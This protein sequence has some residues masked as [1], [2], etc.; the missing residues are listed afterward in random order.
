MKH[1]KL[2]AL[3]LTLIFATACKEDKKETEQI[4]ETEVEEVAEGTKTEKSITVTM[5]PKSDSN[6]T[7]TVVFTDRDGVVTMEGKFSGLTE[8]VHAIHLHEKADCSSP[9]GKSS[10]GHWNPTGQPHGAWGAESGFHKGDIGNMTANAEGNAEISLTTDQWC[11]GCGDLSKNIM[12]KA[13]IVHQGEDDLT[14]QPS[15]AAGAR[16]SCAGIIE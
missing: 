13:V 1:L 5:S 2:I 4:I 16:V 8:G 14:S 15:G 6:V 11:I 3:A 12:G 7:G 9:D 10:G